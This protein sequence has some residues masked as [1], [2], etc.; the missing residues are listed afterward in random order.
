MQ[1]RYFFLFIATILLTLFVL[2]SCNGP[3]VVENK[4]TV[5]NEKPILKKTIKIDNS[6]VNIPGKGEFLGYKVVKVH[7]KKVKVPVYKGDPNRDIQPDKLACDW[8]YIDVYELDH[9][10]LRPGKWLGIWT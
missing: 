5:K 10:R 1:K 2:Y 9:Y 8:Y 4:K 6:A 3:N 7:G